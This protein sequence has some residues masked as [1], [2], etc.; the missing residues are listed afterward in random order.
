MWPFLSSS[1]HAPLTAGQII[2]AVHLQTSTHNYMFWGHGVSSC[3]QKVGWRRPSC[4][5]LMT[6]TANRD[7]RVR[8]FEIDAEWSVKR[9]NPIRLE[10]HVISMTRSYTTSDP[11][12]SH[13]FVSDQSKVLESAWCC[14]HQRHVT[15]SRPNL[16]HA[17]MQDRMTS[18]GLHFS[19]TFS[20]QSDSRPFH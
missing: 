13:E 18:L 2:V 1:S 4:D 20:T 19:E 11:W 5:E 15:W 6:A 3:K 12:F 16:S 8:H 7:W 10:S 9:V 17:V 14:S